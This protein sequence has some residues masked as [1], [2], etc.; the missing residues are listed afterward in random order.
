M[1]KTPFLMLLLA[2]VATLSSCDKCDAEN[3]RAKLINQSST[4]ASVQIKT[5]DGNT[6]NLNNVPAGSAS[7]FRSYAA[8]KVTFTVTVDKA[9]YKK[10]VHMSECYEYIITVDANYN[11]TA[12]SI[13]RND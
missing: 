7:D 2:F 3:P 1:K 6:E 9:D 12:T 13:D 10:D 8:G 4:V 11:I 5:S